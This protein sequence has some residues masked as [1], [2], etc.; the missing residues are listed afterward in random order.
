QVCCNPIGVPANQKAGIWKSTD[1][2]LTWGSGPL[3]NNGLMYLNQSRL[4]F[5]GKDP[6]TL[7]APT[8]GAG[9]FEGTI[10]CDDQLR[11]N[12]CSTRLNASA[13]VVVSGAVQSGGLSEIN[14]GSLDDTEEVLVETGTANHKHL[15]HVWTF[16]SGSS[17]ISYELV[18]EAYDVYLND[19]ESFNFTFATRDSGSCT[20]SESYSSAI[21]TVTK[22]ADDDQ[23]QKASL[24]YLPAGKTVFCIKVNDGLSWDQDVDT[25]HVDRLY[26][27]AKQPL[28]PQLAVSDQTI[29][30]A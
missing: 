25:L 21:L 14:S 10:T 26:L 23:V 29:S 8:G 6:H 19:P 16:P 24:G 3:A 4:V 27:R 13:G 1:G 15:S 2:G 11:D 28:S 7:Y 5:S 30:G 12:E 17:T 20:G 18:V 9:L 22:T